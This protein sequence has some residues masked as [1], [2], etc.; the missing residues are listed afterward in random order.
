MKRTAL[1]LLLCLLAFA[2]TAQSPVTVIGPITPGDCAAFSSTTII[3]DCGIPIS[4]IDGN[5]LNSQTA[6]YAIQSTDCSKIIQ[7]GTGSTGFFTV[8][9]PV[10]SGFASNCKV[11]I[12]NGDTARAK[13]LSG[14]PSNLPA[15]LWPLQTIVV[16][17]VNGA[18]IANQPAGRW[19]LSGAVTAFIDNSVGSDSNDCLAAGAGNACASFTAAIGRMLNQWDTSSQ[20]VTFQAAS[21]QIWNNISL[22]SQVTR[23]SIIIDGGGGT[24]TSSTGAPALQINTTRA[25][26][27]VFLQNV[28]ITCSGGGPGIDVINGL[29]VTQAG[30]TY[31]SCPGGQHRLVANG[32][33][34]TASG[35]YTITGGAAAHIYADSQSLQDDFQAITVT[36]TGAPAFSQAFAVA[37]LNGTVFSGG[38]T[39]SGATTGN[40]YAAQTNGFVSS[41][42]GGVHYFP[43]N[44]EGFSTTGGHYDTPGTPVISACGTS[45]SVATGTDTSGKVTE[46]TTATGCTIAFTTANQPNACSVSISNATAQAGLVISTL[47][48]TTMTVTHP[49]VS[50]AVLY[51]TC[52][53]N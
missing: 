1:A 30:M 50:N 53:T 38:V 19:K 3:K 6:N 42:G 22:P 51:W 40:R 34:M 35:N 4:G 20:T 49:S 21:S 16:E 32:G 47:N 9:L 37:V 24:F 17:I 52:P 18:W 44:S 25:L 26:G 33:E 5:V 41:V 45:P 13:G 2:A 8:T 7:A 29:T 48:S 43:G 36:I 46:G 11:T 23:G 15:F 39:F 27:T 14:F 28:T 12:T 31:G 10:V